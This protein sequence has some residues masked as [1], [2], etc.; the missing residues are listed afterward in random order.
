MG[1][2][3]PELEPGQQQERLGGGR[4]TSDCLRLRHRLQKLGGALQKARSPWR[5]VRR[6]ILRNKHPPSSNP[7]QF[8]DG[9]AFDCIHTSY[10][11]VRLIGLKCYV[12]HST[13]PEL[14]FIK[15]VHAKILI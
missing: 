1:A 3:M 13:Y 6:K 12:Q 9:F 7:S 8:I 4:H 2:G 15:P 10:V 11:H 5:Q 14:V